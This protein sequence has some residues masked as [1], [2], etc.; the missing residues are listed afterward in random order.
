MR[1]EPGSVNFFFKENSRNV[2]VWL[3]CEQ[4]GEFIGNN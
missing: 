4:Q 1:I 2:T 3:G